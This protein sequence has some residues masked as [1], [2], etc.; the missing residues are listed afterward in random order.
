MRFGKR[1]AAVTQTGWASHS[2]FVS[3]KELKKKLG[4]ITRVLGGGRGRGGD[5]SCDDE[6]PSTAVSG[7]HDASAWNGVDG[8]AGSEPVVASEEV[9]VHLR[10]FFD[11]LSTDLT[12]AQNHMM[13]NVA[14]LE[15]AVGEWQELA[16][17]SGLLF[18]EAQLEEVRAWHSTCMPTA[19]IP[20]KHALAAWIVDMQGSVDN[21]ARLNTLV[22]K[23][24]GIA[25]ILNGLLQFVEVNLMA[26]RKILKKYEK[27]V[28]VSFRAKY[29][30]RNYRMHHC[31][32]MSSFQHILLTVLHM[33]GLVEGLIPKVPQ[34]SMKDSVIPVSQIGPESLAI[35]S[36]L[37]GPVSLD[38]ILAAASATKIDVYAKPDLGAGK[39][40]DVYA[41]PAGGVGTAAVDSA[42]VTTRSTA[43]NNTGGFAAACPAKVAFTPMAAH[44]VG[45]VD[46]ATGKKGKGG[47]ASRGSRRRGGR[48]GRG[49]GREGGK[50]G[51]NS[52]NGGVGINAIGGAGNAC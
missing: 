28:P 31:L 50:Q 34:Q 47:T 18:T 2:P 26:T 33:Y 3:Y 7:A 41:K 51:G 29:D 45:S 37:R 23:Y 35:L 49:S 20:D 13:S 25:K 6:F 17:R 39:Q 10:D 44:T 38:E 36:W 8:I 15:T 48:G 11:H 19:P 1:L 21:H 52:S 5:S 30:A 43:T 24:S 9:E 4:V 16:I 12:Q 27:K 40:I 46:S 22:E 14:L 32:L 42:I